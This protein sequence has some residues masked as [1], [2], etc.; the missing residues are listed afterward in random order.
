MVKIVGDLLLNFLFHT[1]CKVTEI[2]AGKITPVK[3]CKICFYIAQEINLLKGGSQGPGMGLQLLKQW[4]VAFTKYGKAHEAH[5]FGTAIDILFITHFIVALLCKICFHALKESIYEGMLDMVLVHGKLKAVQDRVEA[6]AL[7]NGRIGGCF[8]LGQQG[9]FIV[10]VEG[11]H[12][13]IGKTNK[14]IDITDGVAQ[15]GMKEPDRSIK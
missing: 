10:L 15:I 7:T 8:E 5:H 14:A 13:F 3:G 4:L 9:Y 1:G 12:N 11:I 6:D 2:C